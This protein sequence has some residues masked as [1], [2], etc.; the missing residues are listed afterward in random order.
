[1]KQMKIFDERGDHL[2][3]IE[4]LDFSAFDKVQRKYVQPL[5]LILAEDDRRNI[6]CLVYNLEN[7]GKT[8][9][10]VA[11]VILDPSKRCIADNNF[12]D[13]QFG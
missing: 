2:L 4:S 6:P 9:N 3:A 5:Q 1:M 8:I 7:S 11:F 13:L 12:I 10:D